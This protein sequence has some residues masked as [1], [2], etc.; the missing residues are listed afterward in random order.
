[1]A[2]RLALLGRIA[3][4]QGNLFEARIRIAEAV[5]KDPR[6]ISTQTWE[7]L[8]RAHRSADAVSVATLAMLCVRD[9]SGRGMRVAAKTFPTKLLLS[10]R[11]RAS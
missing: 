11:R 10:A 6:A 8:V 2:T 7:A 5:A 1:V 3:A 9:P 4:K